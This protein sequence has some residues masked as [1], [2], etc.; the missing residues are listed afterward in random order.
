MPDQSKPPSFLRRIAVITY[1][2]ILLISVLFLA[3]LILIP[4]QP[5]GAFQPN[6]LL[7]SLYLLIVSFLFYGWFWT[8]G[9]QTLGLQT[10]KL[11][12]IGN[13]KQPIT[14]LQ[15]MV[16]FATALFSWGFA[17]IGFFWIIFNDKNLTWHD[18]ASK[19]HVE[20]YAKK[21]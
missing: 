17:G 16:R 11:R 6:T 5:D 1:D 4:F 20:W 21:P 2:I 15:A 14:W 3:T 18:I 8:H 9:G 12:V 13:N 7:Y 19:S 10:W